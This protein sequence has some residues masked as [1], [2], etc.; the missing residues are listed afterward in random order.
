MTLV[1]TPLRWRLALAAVVVFITAAVL[2]LVTVSGD[3][4]ASKPAAAPSPT[5]TPTPTLPAVPPAPAIVVTPTVRPAPALP[6]LAQDSVSIPSQHVVAPIDVCQII[7]GGL[8]PPA[9]VHRTCSWAGGAQVTASAGTTVITGHI[10]WVGQGTG[11]LGNI[12][13]LHHGA[14]VF[15]SGGDGEVTKWTVVKVTHRPKT[16]GIDTA[17]FVGPA[18]PRT[19]YLISCG[20]A[21]DAA[22]ASY[23]DNI[24]VQAVPASAAVSHRLPVGA[25]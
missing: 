25:S 17:A 15:T 9:D 21:F 14:T 7:N 19:L 12:G 6:K 16:T 20:G 3:D 13:K 1:L 22:E 4:S 10:N 5:L 18:G 23:L 24:Y 2:G 11:A 8:E